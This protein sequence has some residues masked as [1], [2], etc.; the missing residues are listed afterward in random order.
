[1]NTTLVTRDIQ[2][3]SSAAS[4]ATAPTITAPQPVRWPRP[5]RFAPA[6]RRPWGRDN[7]FR[8]PRLRPAIS[9]S[10][11]V[12]TTRAPDDVVVELPLGPQSC[13]MVSATR[14]RLTERGIAVVLVAGLMIVVAGLTV[15]T[16]TA[17][18]VTSDSY[19]ISGQVQG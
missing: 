8:G 15:V 10:F 12:G 14:W 13:A 5:R 16:A 3:T 1:M 2:A 11:G 19:Q 18:R 9:P 6:V 17:L 4:A 7:R